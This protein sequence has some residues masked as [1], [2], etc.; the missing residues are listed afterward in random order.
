MPDAATQLGKMIQP[1]APP[2]PSAPAGP[3]RPDALPGPYTTKLSPDEELKFRLWAADPKNN[4][5]QYLAS[6][7]PDYDMRG[8]WKA[9]VSGDPNAK[10]G[11]NLHFPDT[12]KTPYHRS[13]SNE[14]KY[15]LPD[16]PHW[17]DDYRQVDP[18]GSVTWDDR[19]NEDHPRPAWEPK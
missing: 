9:M 7:F 14:S 19:W 11:G 10:R 8:F 12:Y 4:S 6:K 18:H 3:A 2:S 16:A 15:A 1:P 13:F 5:M 17:V